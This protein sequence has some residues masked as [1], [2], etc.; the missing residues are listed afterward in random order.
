ML[1][2][3]FIRAHSQVVKAMCQKRGLNIDIQKIIDLDSKR[4]RLFFLIEDGKKKFKNLKE[5]KKYYDED[6]YEKEKDNLIKE[7]KNSQQDLKENI[8][9]LK[10]NMLLLPNITDMQVPFGDNINNSKIIKIT[11]KDFDN[12]ENNISDK[13]YKKAIEY[14][15]EKSFMDF[16]K[17]KFISDKNEFLMHPIAS[18]VYI[19]S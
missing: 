3:S 9:E 10:R 17:I 1:D 4:K 16:G 19:S 14:F 5:S 13:N 6:D 8:I 12:S 2:I 11:G 7:I 18:K 15:K